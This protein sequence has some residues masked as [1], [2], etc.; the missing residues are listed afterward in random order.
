MIPDPKLEIMIK[1]IN[2]K[3]QNKVGKR[4]DM[5]ETFYQIHNGS[6]YEGQTIPEFLEEALTLVYKEAVA[7]GRKE[8][9]ERVKKII[10]DTSNLTNTQ[11]NYIV[12]KLVEQLSPE[13]VKE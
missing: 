4:I 1:E 5:L 7:N 13:G 9:R 2:K 11:A 10:G 8:E 12:A 3:F 6:P